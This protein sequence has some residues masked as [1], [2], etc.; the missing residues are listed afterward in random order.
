MKI[1]EKYNRE[2]SYL[3]IISL[4]Y[5][6]SAIFVQ[7]IN[8][9]FSNG[10]PV[11]DE[12][13]YALPI[14]TLLEQKKF[15]VAEGYAAWAL[16]QTFIGYGV[17]RVFG[18]SF[19]NMRYIN[20]FFCL[21]NGLL[22]Y[23]VF[24]KYLRINY[25]ISSYVLFLFLFFPPIFINSVIFQSDTIFLFFLITSVLFFYIY[26]KEKSYSYL[27]LFNFFSLLCIAQRQ[28]GI[29]LS[30]YM[31]FILIKNFKDR[32]FLIFSIIFQTT[33]F[34]II[35]KGWIEIIGETN[36]FEVFNLGIY[37]LIKIN[38]NI[39]QIIVY[40]GM[41][42]VPLIFFYAFEKNFINK[43]KRYNF[44]VAIFFLFLVFFIFLK[45]NM[46]MPYFDNQYSKF[47]VFRL[48]EILRGKREYF[49]SDFFYIGLTFVSSVASCILYFCLYEKWKLIFKNNLLNIYIVIIG[50]FTA[51][52]LLLFIN[53]NDRYLIPFFF[54][55][56]LLLGLIM[57]KKNILKKF[58]F[59]T[60]IFCIL[61][62]LFNIS[63]SI[64]ITQDMFT[65]SEKRWSLA[66]EFIKKKNI[67][68]F[69]LDAGHEWNWIY[70]LELIKDKNENGHVSN[71]EIDQKKDQKYRIVFGSDNHGLLKLKFESYFRRGE[72]SVI[73]IK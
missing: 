49:F 57:K 4:I 43:I 61:F 32:K 63:V 72:I 24:R 44:V 39:I 25:I 19:I 9:T 18:F 36:P 68:S 6:L 21:L 53:F 15:I 59:I 64:L 11:N 56:F 47:G 52:S 33:A 54:I 3:F 28:L 16:P 17:S 38:F 26:Q 2:I 20:I 65:W 22:L 37:K 29:V 40:A 41:V 46:L 58:N 62:L 42:V 67:S 27:F 13:Y 14:V 8:F 10:H 34:L 7:P 45:F 12:F 23:F 5:F 73:K 50:I 31:I 48:D 30:A 1:I 70:H 60:I 51:S 66:E 69:E 71:I 35:Y 55:L